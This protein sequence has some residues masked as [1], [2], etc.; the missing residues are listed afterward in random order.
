M[1][2]WQYISG[3]NLTDQDLD[4]AG[5]L[6]WELVSVVARSQTHISSIFYFKRPVEQ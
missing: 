4:N 6:G 1:I 5:E 2:K 3:Y